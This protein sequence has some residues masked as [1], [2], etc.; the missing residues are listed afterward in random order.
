MGHFNIIQTKN[1]AI[2]AAP[3][4]ASTNLVE[5]FVD[6]FDNIIE[7]SDDKKLPNIIIVITRKKGYCKKQNK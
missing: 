3:K 5:F 6:R 1:L 4:T 7:T 2:T